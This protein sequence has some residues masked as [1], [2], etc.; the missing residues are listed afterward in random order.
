MSTGVA[1]QDHN[2]LDTVAQRPT[3]P[4][5]RSRFL[6]LAWLLLPL[7]GAL[8][9]VFSSRST[10]GAP[11]AA[12]P[13]PIVAV[14]PPP[15]AAPAALP[16]TPSTKAAESS[17]TPPHD[18]SA[19]TQTDPFG[20]LTSAPPTEKAPAPAT[21]PERVAEP[22][23]PAPTKAAPPAASKPAAKSVGNVPPA[24]K[25]AATARSGASK[26]DPDVELLNAIMKHLDDGAGKAPARSA[27]TIAEL[28]K[29]CQS[30]DAIDALLCQRRICEGSWG[31]AQACPMHL[32]PKSATKT[33]AH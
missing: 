11:P 29:S 21:R 26:V 17:A 32:A 12:P 31:K 22:A 10:P 20:A 6:Q 8:G 4:A 28:V 13:A 24:G 5:V 15:P 9:W 16:E 7:I 23:M 1:A 3:A 2:I 33:A 25:P 18:I 27:R 30:R 14:A 19:G